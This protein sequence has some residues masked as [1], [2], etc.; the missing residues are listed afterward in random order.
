MNTTEVSQKQT[1]LVTG[2]SRGLGLALARSLAASGWSLLIDG[3][4]PTRLHAA[5]T[6]LAGLTVVHAIPGDITDARHR[7]QLA[8][9]SRELG[10]L[11]LVIHNAGILGPSPLPPLAEAPVEALREVFETNVVAQLALTQAVLPH[12]RPG[13][14]IVAI[15]SDAAN[16]AYP[17]WGLYGASKA[18]LEQLFAVF[19]EE[20]PELRVLRI[21]P[22]DLRT[23]M[24]QAAFP[25][26]DISD[27]P[28]P[29]ARVPAMRN[30]L[31]GPFPS[32]RYR[33]AELVEEVA[34]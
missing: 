20:H 12:L 10:G 34:R 25:G 32:G 28:L 24:H 13:A 16:E 3:R 14:V 11:D 17:G 19:A 31:E 2:A 9:A 23:D 26:D 18:A 22:G 33:A 4:D 6:E 7:A 27:R 29:A 30:L 8:A 21:D 5:A 1:A 15:T